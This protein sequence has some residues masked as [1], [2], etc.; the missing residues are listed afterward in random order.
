MT[1]QEHIDN[2]MDWFDFDRVHS[3]M[4]HLNWYWASTNGVPEKAEL[5][6]YVRKHMTYVYN[7]THSKEGGYF[8]SGGF[9]I[10][11]Y[12]E[13]D[14]FNVQFILSSWGTNHG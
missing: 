1:L 13:E 4:T 7:Q 8:C 14:C 12:R 10:E 2:V 3:V 6:A 9:E 11:Y 5:R